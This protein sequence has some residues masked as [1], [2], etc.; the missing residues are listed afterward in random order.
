MKMFWKCE[1]EKL[2]FVMEEDEENICE[3]FIDLVNDHEVK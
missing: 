2:D 1:K 3:R